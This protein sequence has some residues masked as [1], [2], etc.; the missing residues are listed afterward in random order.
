[1]LAAIKQQNA[2]QHLAEKRAKFRKE[3]KKAEKKA[4][5]QKHNQTSIVKSKA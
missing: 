3:A 4:V 5:Q 2:E 1:M